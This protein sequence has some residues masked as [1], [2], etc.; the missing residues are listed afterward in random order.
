MEIVFNK[1]IEEANKAEIEKY[2]TQFQWIIPAW[3]QALNVNIESTENESLIASC[4][5]QERYREAALTIRPLFFTESEAVK[6][7][8]IIH[9]LFHIHTNPL[10]D[11]AKN[12]IR[13]FS[14]DENEKA[15][16]IVFDEMDCY[17]ERATQDL[18]KVIY[19]K[20][21]GDIQ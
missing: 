18:T 9:E 2:L 8:T 15:M 4:Q 13:K 1:N 5:V 16:E 11:F 21:K 12:A 19:D 14:E 17:L 10:Y 6:T 20:F 7:D 3:V